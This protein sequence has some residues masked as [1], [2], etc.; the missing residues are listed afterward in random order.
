M[1][2]K[3]ILSKIVQVEIGRS[4]PFVPGQSNVLLQICIKHFVR[5]SNR[6]VCLCIMHNLEIFT[7]IYCD[8]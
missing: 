2:T 8:C 7:T 5:I 4:F 1:T 6:I 3:R